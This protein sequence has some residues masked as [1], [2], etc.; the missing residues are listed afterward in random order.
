MGD[1]AFRSFIQDHNHD[2]TKQLLNNFEFSNTLI[3]TFTVDTV[4]TFPQHFLLSGSL[5]NT[6]HAYYDSGHV[7]RPQP[8]VAVSTWFCSL[9]PTWLLNLIYFCMPSGPFQTN[10]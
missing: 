10:T 2:N 4:M 7:G 8:E 5:G 6:H 3:C 9:P 1:F